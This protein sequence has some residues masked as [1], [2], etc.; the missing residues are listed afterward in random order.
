[1]SLEF[2]DISGL[3][4]R[5]SCDQTSNFFALGNADFIL[6]RE[7]LKSLDLDSWPFSY[8]NMTEKYNGVAE[9]EWSE[10]S[11]QVSQCE[12]SFLYCVAPE[13]LCKHYWNINGQD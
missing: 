7:W 5:M 8:V 6:R 3:Y 4:P 12:L 2:F 11:Q 9:I 13:T 10:K 1:M